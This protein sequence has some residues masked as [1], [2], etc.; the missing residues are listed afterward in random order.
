M[1]A[2]RTSK[3]TRIVSKYKQNQDVLHDH[4]L[5]VGMGVNV[6]KIFPRTARAFFDNKQVPFVLFCSK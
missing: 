3:L 4:G 2:L 6:L 1:K 5:I